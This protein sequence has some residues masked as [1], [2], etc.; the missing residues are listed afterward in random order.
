MLPRSNVGRSSHEGRLRSEAASVDRFYI[1]LC[2]KAVSGPGGPYKYLI[3]LGLR[4]VGKVFAS[5]R[6]KPD[7]CVGHR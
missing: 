3:R 5:N 6:F 2:R 1:V 7:G 4:A